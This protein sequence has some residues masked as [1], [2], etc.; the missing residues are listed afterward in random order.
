MKA[1]PQWAEERTGDDT[2]ISVFTWMV[3]FFIFWGT[4][5]P[6]LGRSPGG[7]HCNP[8]QYSCLENPVDRGVW[9]VMVHRVAKSWT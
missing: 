9:T 5:I 6:E 3:S 8:L 4:S 1:R 7:S 2:V